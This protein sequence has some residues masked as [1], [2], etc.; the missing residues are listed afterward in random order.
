MK[1]SRLFLLTALAVTCLTG[2]GSHNLNQEF[3][4][5]A[6]SYYK[7]LRQN[8][9][10]AE[11]EDYHAWYFDSSVLKGVV[12]DSLTNYKY[13]GIINFQTFSFSETE[14]YYVDI[15][16]YDV[17]FDLTNGEFELPEVFKDPINILKDLPLVL[18]K[19][20]STAKTFDKKVNVYSKFTKD[21]ALDANATV[22]NYDPTFYYIKDF[23]YDIDVKDVSEDILN[24]FKIDY[25]GKYTAILKRDIYSII[26]AKL[27]MDDLPIKLDFYKNLVDVYDKVNLLDGTQ[28]LPDTLEFPGTFNGK[29]VVVGPIGL[30]DDLLEGIIEQEEGEAPVKSASHEIKNIVLNEGITELSIFAFNKCENLTE[31]ELPSTIKKLCL[32]SLSNLTNLN[33]VLIPYTA[34]PIDIF[35]IYGTIVEF[36]HPF[37]EGAKITING[38]FENSTINDA[39]YFE[40]FENKNVSN[41]PYF[42]I[43]FANPLADSVKFVK[44]FDNPKVENLQEGF[45]Q[46]NAI[47]PLFM[48]DLPSNNV[49]E[50]GDLGVIPAGK[51]LYV[52]HSKTMIS[53][54]ILG[55][56]I[57]RYREYSINEP[58]LQNYL[59]FKL[60]SDLAIEGNVIVGGIIG[61]DENDVGKVVNKY[62]SIDLNGHILTI[63]SGGVLDCNGRIFDSSATKTGKIY[64]QDGGTLKG[65]YVTSDNY[66]YDNY[67]AKAFNNDFPYHYYSFL[68]FDVKEIVVMHNGDLIA[69]ESRS[70]DSVNFYNNQFYFVTSKEN[71]NAL[72][73]SKDTTDVFSILYNGT[74]EEIIIGGNYSLN[75]IELFVKN[76]NNFVNTENMYFPIAN[77]KLDVLVYGQLELNVPVKIL[78]GGT[79]NVFDLGEL[80]LNKSLVVYPATASEHNA[81]NLTNL[82][83]NS[84][85]LVVAGELSCDDDIVL[86]GPIYASS[87]LAYSSVYNIANKTN[88]IPTISIDEGAFI[89]D[90]Y[91]IQ[92]TVD[93]ELKIYD[94]TNKLAYYRFE[95]GYAYKYEGDV[96]TIFN[97]ED[98]TT[99]ATKTGDE[100]WIANVGGTDV[101]TGIYTTTIKS[102]ETLT[103]HY[104]LEDTGN[105]ATVSTEDSFHTY[106]SADETKRYIMVKNEEDG[107][108][109]LVEGTLLSGEKLIFKAKI[110]GKTYHYDNLNIGHEWTYCHQFEN[111]YIIAYPVSQSLP[112]NA[113]YIKENYSKTLFY[114]DPIFVAVHDYDASRHIIYDKV[115]T[116]VH[117]HIVDNVGTL[118]EIDSEIT[119]RGIATSLE[120]TG[121]SYVFIKKDGAWVAFNSEAIEKGV[122]IQTSSTKYAYTSRNA[123]ERCKYFNNAETYG[124]EFV[125]LLDSTDYQRNFAII[126]QT[127]EEYIANLFV[128]NG[129]VQ[130]VKDDLDGEGLKNLLPEGDDEYLG[131]RYITKGNRYYVIIEE[132]GVYKLVQLENEPI[133]DT[134]D[135]EVD[136][137]LKLNKIMSL[138]KIT[139]NGTYYYVD[140]NN[141]VRCGNGKQSLKELDYLALATY[142]LDPPNVADMFEND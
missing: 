34:E 75:K 133:L 46:V 85:R 28:A 39:V 21:G 127:G 80:I 7:K 131:Y 14:D 6:L 22:E 106:K 64:V 83:T 5:E 139:V 1:K 17:K 78:N 58:A 70:D 56:E 44:T 114:K 112:V 137:K 16:N 110:D 3:V 65:N 27:N 2:C 129:G 43:N 109:K 115:G 45:A 99:I 54:E 116:I 69:K 93:A 94:E 73:V 23:K 13:L 32:S 19:D 42:D 20:T 61:Q 41:F 140:F 132:E 31:V 108:S 62:G 122:I 84:G 10:I 101:T 76:G 48:M 111:G 87:A 8:N 118:H 59:T 92:Y 103:D 86:S 105:W 90:E 77:A 97:L 57:S 125:E 63:S 120:E 121:I 36:D 51:T 35:N 141:L 18:V 130:F 29:E 126:E 67:E 60:S 124:F 102:F 15:P 52:P 89:G 47:N 72:Y 37:K 135:R 79:L 138:S 24:Q 25:T 96:V 98:N 33:R 12:F 49:F 11:N 123:W 100:A 66:S 38:P 107:T 4:N 95:E 71:V 91:Q 50:N 81:T 128:K 136:G 119:E 88:I 68:D 134:Y 40:R 74:K 142:H 30:F 113:S 55:P 117:L 104:F 53:S 82:G 26:D 9:H